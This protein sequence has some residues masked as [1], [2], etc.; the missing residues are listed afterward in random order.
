MPAILAVS[1]NGPYAE[2]DCLTLVVRRGY[3]D[4]E[5]FRRGD[6]G[7]PRRLTRHQE[8]DPLAAAA[9]GEDNKKSSLLRVGVRRQET[10]KALRNDAESTVWGGLF[11]ELSTNATYYDDKAKRDYLVQGSTLLHWAAAFNA[12][13]SV[14]VGRSSSG[15]NV[16]SSVSVHGSHW[17][18][19]GS[20][21]AEW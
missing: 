12:R 17:M 21:S 4:A 8:R 13:R 14:E 20:Q 3:L 11:G 10:L 7:R 2:A 6:E 5:G 15:G 1:I 19:S 9:P 18:S 16:R